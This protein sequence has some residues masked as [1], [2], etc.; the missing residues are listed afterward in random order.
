MLMRPDSTFVSYLERNVSAVDLK[1]R[2]PFAIEP[3]DMKTRLILLGEV[4]GMQIGQELDFAMLRMLNASSGVRW[5]VGEFDP[6]QAAQFN[7]YLVD[8]DESRLRRVFGFWVQENAQWANREFLEKIRKI[9]ALNQSLPPE[10][11]IRFIG[12]DRVQDMPL[13]ARHLDVILASVPEGTWPGQA[14]LIKTLQS[15]A[16]RTENKPDAPLPL[17]AVAADETLPPTAP[18]GIDPALWKLLR[19]SV[20]NLSDRALLKGRERAITASFQRLAADPAFANERAYGL[21]GQ[22]HVLNATVQGAEP[23][24]RQLQNGDSSFKGQILSVT[25]VNLDS[26]MMLPA[27]SFGLKEPYIEIPYSLDNPLLIF[28]S[29]INEVK[30]A[31]VSP[32]SLFKLNAEQT[33]YPGTDKLGTVGGFLSWLQPFSL[34]ATSVGAEGAMQ[35]AILERASG[36]LTPLTL[37]ETKA[38]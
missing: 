9:K 18:Q 19:E 30:Q 28:V 23:F 3:A 6:A 4:H 32:L 8:G 16:A 13:M 38:E 33:P 26:R 15:D 24:V 36:A 27:Q 17:A 29:G 11:R 35:Y 12:M 20:K 1:G 21:W 14:G 25:I 31:A 34:D 7:A 2:V 10:Q 37:A 5:Y 22:F